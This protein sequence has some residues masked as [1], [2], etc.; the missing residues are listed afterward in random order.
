VKTTFELTIVARDRMAYH[1]QAQVCTV[2]GTTGSRSFEAHHEKFLAVLASPS[3][4][5]FRDEAGQEKQVRIAGGLAGF[6]N[7]A[8]SLVVE[9]EDEARS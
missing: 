6:T 5:T 7:N 2:V 1:G 4:V 8:C 9:L 3:L